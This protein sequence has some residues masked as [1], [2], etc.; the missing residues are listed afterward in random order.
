MNLA[1]ENQ[2]LNTPKLM[3]Q[4]DSL[5]S[6]GGLSDE[7]QLLPLLRDLTTDEHVPLITRNH[8]ARLLKR[9]EK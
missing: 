7:Y 3:E 1:R 5:I 2:P 9:I 6:H 8:A 4:L